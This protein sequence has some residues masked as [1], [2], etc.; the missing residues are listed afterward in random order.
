MAACDDSDSHAKTDLQASC[1]L[2]PH[3]EEFRGEECAS[4]NKYPI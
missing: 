2:W 1:P 3:F 4:K